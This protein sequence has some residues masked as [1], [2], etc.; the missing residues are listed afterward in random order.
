M[1]KSERT[2]TAK[3]ENRGHFRWIPSVAAVSAMLTF[4]SGCVTGETWRPFTYDQL[5]PVRLDPQDALRSFHNDKN[6]LVATLTPDSASGRP[7]EAL[8]VLKDFDAQ[9]LLICGKVKVDAG[10]T[11][12]YVFRT[13]GQSGIVTSTYA[14]VVSAQ[15]VE[16][17]QLASLGWLPLNRYVTS[18]PPGIA[19]ELRVT[20]KGDKIAVFLEGLLLFT[21]RDTSLV[22]DGGVGLYARNGVCTFENVRVQSLNRDRG[23]ASAESHDSDKTEPMP[24]ASQNVPPDASQHDQEKQLQ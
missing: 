12:G 10:A 17:W 7:V 3:V 20:V 5:H 6:F 13:R 8:A 16:L 14:L 11:A 24:A 19:R 23:H 15:G 21:S 9:D 22:H 1:R 2:A 4:F 18:L